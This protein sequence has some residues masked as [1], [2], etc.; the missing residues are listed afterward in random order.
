MG[1]LH[2]DRATRHSAMNGLAVSAAAGAAGV[3][4]AAAVA[5]PGRTAVAAQP[6][7]SASPEGSSTAAPAVSVSLGGVRP[8]A[9]ARATPTPRPHFKTF[10]VPPCVPGVY[11]TITYHKPVDMFIP[12]LEYVD[13]PGGEMEVWLK[14]FYLI[15]F[16][17]SLEREIGGDFNVR[18][19]TA[20]IR[21]ML[22]P[23]IEEEH[24]IEVGHEYVANI[25]D[26]HYGHLRYRVFGVRFGFNVWRV[27]HNCGRLRVNSGTATFPTIREGWKYWETKTLRRRTTSRK[28]TKQPD[29]GSPEP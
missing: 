27:F 14:R 17:I 21:K 9:S 16:H 12:H 3:A 25:H 22:S 15:R 23:E 2:G 11:Y 26:H 24:A 13:G 19:F 7:A 20:K 8:A 5:I 4:L 10:V 18:D 28:V 29:H 1:S 6:T